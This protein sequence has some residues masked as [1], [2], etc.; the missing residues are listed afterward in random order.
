MNLELNSKL[1]TKSSDNKIPQNADGCKRK[2]EENC[3]SD[4]G[5]QTPDIRLF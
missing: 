5:L 1:K 3:N 2:D 4:N